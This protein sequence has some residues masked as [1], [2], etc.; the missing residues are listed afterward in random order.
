MY[1]AQSPDDFLIM[2]KLHEVRDT[3][4]CKQSFERQVMINEDSILV[5]AY[6]MEGEDQIFFYD[7]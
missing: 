5:Q 4:E 6:C 7:T 2:I 3:P 1:W